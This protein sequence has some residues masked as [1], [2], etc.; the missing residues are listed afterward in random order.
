MPAPHDL[1]EPSRTSG[2]HVDRFDTTERRSILLLALCLLVALGGSW[3]YFERML[4]ANERPRLLAAIALVERGG[5]RLDEIAAQTKLALGPDVARAQDGGLVPNKPPGATLVASVAYVASKGWR[6]SRGEPLDRRSYTHWS[7]ALGALLPTCLLAFV[8]WQ[9]QREQL[10]RASDARPAH[11]DFSLVS[12]LL[13]TPAWA[14][15]KLLFGH[16]LAAA[17][18]GLGLVALAPARRPFGWLRAGLGGLSCGAAVAVEYTAVFAGP[19]IAAWLI[20]HYR[21]KLDVIAAALVGATLPI[22]ALALYHR[23]VFGSVWTTGYHAVVREEF[24]EIHGRG[25]LGLQVPTLESVWEHLLSPWGG[26]LVWAPL[27]LLGLLAGAWTALRSDDP[28]ERARHGLFAAVGLSLFVVLLG[29][30]QGGGWR[31]GPRY[32]VLAMPLAL[33]GLTEL[34]SQLSRRGERRGLGFALV[35]GLF[36]SSFVLQALAANW[37]PHLI[38]GGNPVGDLLWPLARDGY[39]PHGLPRA[40]VL[41]CAIGAVAIVLARLYHTTEHGA[42]AWVGGL[43]LALLIVAAHGL[44][45]ASDIDAE[46]QLEA[47]E[48]I[49]EPSPTGE[50]PSSVILFEPFGPGG[51]TKPSRSRGSAAIHARQRCQY[52]RSCSELGSGTCSKL[53]AM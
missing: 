10:G 42:A 51:P 29:L 50:S 16:S 41:G 18:L 1:E 36:G 20:W 17:L 35:L 40:L 49:Y 26:L 27:V 44:G 3:P 9:R 38:P 45:P 2:A 30:E 31:V 14:N 28:H 21:N 37:F 6:A 19:A 22:A 43:A 25:L 33:P 5:V 24:A 15:A 46:Q 13:A 32:F 48:A 4:D 34:V 47:V 52:A 7:R 39:W 11:V 23:V 12:W 8:L 53:L